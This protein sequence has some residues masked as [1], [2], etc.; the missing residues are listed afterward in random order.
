LTWI[1]QKFRLAGRLEPASYQ[2]ATVLNTLGYGVD[3]LEDGRISIKFELS[4]NP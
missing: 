3:G 1:S 2:Y 4:I